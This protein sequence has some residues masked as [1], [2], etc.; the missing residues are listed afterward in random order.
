MGELIGKEYVDCYFPNSYKL[1][2]LNMV[3]NIKNAFE[4]T[5]DNLDWMGDETKKK[6]KLKLQLMQVK[7]G[8]PDKWTDYSDLSLNDDFF[9][10][11]CH[12][13]I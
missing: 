10:N 4:E 8:F 6:A 12:V 2:V 1:D 11:I 5:I 3:D 13:E 9:A 7:M